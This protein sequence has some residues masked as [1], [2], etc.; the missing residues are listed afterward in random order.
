MINSEYE[1]NL[2]Y[3]PSCNIE[4]AAIHLMGV[5]RSDL[6]PQWF[7][8]PDDQLYG[9]WASI[10]AYQLL[11][12]EWDDAKS[13]LIE[14]KH[15]KAPD[16]VI[17]ALQVEISHCSERVRLANSYKIAIINELAK[18]VGFSDLHIDSTATSD[19]RNPFIT[20]LSLKHWAHKAFNISILAELDPDKPVK[21]LKKMREQEKVILDE[22]T[23]LGYD[24]ISLPKLPPGKRGI[25]AEVRTSLLSHRLF[26][27]KTT[28]FDKSWE[29]LSKENISYKK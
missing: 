6:Q 7:P 2:T 15:E 13:K 17:V 24:P 21:P 29:R 10:E 23:R 12:E 1:I 9:E 27:D 20:L 11:T 18:G 25:K 3:A 8:D 4:D 5:P 14:A 16:E 28:V 22:L 19:T 26:K